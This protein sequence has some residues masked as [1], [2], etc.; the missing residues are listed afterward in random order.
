MT[1]QRALVLL[2]AVLV[3]LLPRVAE[4]CPVC[5]GKEPGGTA[6]IAALGVMI[7]LPFLITLVVVR[8]IRSSDEETDQ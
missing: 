3:L 6:K 2:S 1:P 4:A 5:V 8:T 7:L